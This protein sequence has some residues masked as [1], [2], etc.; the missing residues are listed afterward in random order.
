MILNKS[1]LVEN[2]V[3]EL[4]DNSTGLISPHDIRHNLLDIID[5]VHLLTG[6]HNLN[7]RNFS[8][9]STRTTRV[10]EFTIENLNLAGY[11][12]IDN[13]AFGYEA[14]K[15]NYQGSKNTALG[16]K[17]LFC[18]VY[19]ENNVA[20]GHSSLS[21]N[22]T[23][24]G[25]VA[26]GNFALS[27]NRVGNF[28]IAIGHSAGYYIDR[29]DSY[30]LFIA[31]HPVNEEY[32]CENPN[33]LGLLPLVFADLSGIRFGIGVSGLHDDSA[34]QVGG[35]ATPSSGDTFNLGSSQ[36]SWKNIF[37]SNSIIGQNGSSLS[38]G[39]RVDISGSVL[40]FNHNQQNF[41]S[42]EKAWASG[43]FKDIVVSNTATIAILNAVE[44]CF[45]PCK[46]LYLAASGCNNNLDF[47]EY[48]SDSELVGAGF[49]IFADNG[50]NIRKYNFD[51]LPPS[52]GFV[53]ENNAFAKA[54]WNSNITIAIDSGS[55][56]K[57]N[58]IASHDP[59]GHG[60][61]FNSGITYLSSHKAL[62]S[63]SALA[64]IGNVNF[65]AQSGSIA[66]YFSSLIAIESGVTIGTR[67]LTGSKRY[68][69]D[70]GNFN[71][72]RLNGFD[73]KYIDD[74]LLGVVD[75]KT[76]RLVIGSYDNTSYNQNVVTILQNN[77]DAIFGINN[78]AQISENTLPKTALDIRSTGNAI[79]RATAENQASTVSAIQLMGEQD[80]L[81]N[82]LEACY[83]NTSGFAD[84]NVYKDASK[85]VFF[86][87]Y[88][89]GRIGVFTSS[90]NANEMLTMGDGFNNKPAISMLEASGTFSSTSKYAKIFVK[91]KITPN[92][93]AT[94]N[95]LDGSGNLHD[96]V[97]NKFDNLDGR[98]LYTDSNRNTFGGL[99]SPKTRTVL[100][101]NTK[102]NTSVGHTSLFNVD[103]G[104]YENT[105]LGSYSGSGITSGY[106]NT[107]IGF[108][109]GRNFSTGN[110]NI[111]LGNNA[112]NN[113]SNSIN[114]NIVIGNSGLGSDSSSNYR[115]YLGANKDLVLL[116]GILG[117]NNSDKILT[118]PSGGKFLL[119]NSN[120]SE[121]LLVRNNAIDV[122][123]YGGSD[124]PD[125][126][127]TFNF[128]GNSSANLFKL[129]H[130]ANPLN[131]TP[132]YTV[133]TTPVP[134]AELKGDLRLLGSIRFSDNTSLS[135]AS[136]IETNKNNITSLNSGLNSINNAISTLIVEGYCPLK[137]DAPTNAS[138]PTTGN[139]VIKNSQWIDSSGVI[140]V[141]RDLSLN[142]PQGAY[143]IAVKV[144][145]E[146]RPLSISSQ[147]NCNVCCQ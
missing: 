77:G 87:L 137:I 37:L 2:I 18:N 30:K 75:G 105:V 101:T 90:G 13:S 38:L 24:I 51:F 88:E 135:S 85:A 65:I 53:F 142:I 98:A 17:A 23:G 67:Y 83:V 115:F 4:S 9:P 96:L 6:E 109:S 15:S 86:R 94:L 78:F 122:Y 125:N 95:L 52:S 55:Y 129:N 70:A 68:S 127:L 28:N 146:Y 143:V 113:T 89:N 93:G 39:S 92:Q 123:D 25:N 42:S 56:L 130:V 10:G 74:A 147:E 14:L 1:Q 138:N 128:I 3:T 124:Y 22:S 29:D 145:N 108:N 80:C 140:L 119:Y 133:P 11:S 62:T 116:Q 45:Y 112:F 54:S 120:N 40:P 61:Y 134:Y 20:V 19:G 103:A 8:T 99:L 50:G 139:L 72:E 27:N 32:L 118:M 34:L 57:T 73:I 41:G 43:Y 136:Q 5:S 69:K 100:N 58:R 60:L 110:S 49:N 81:Y 47:C 46:T 132:T 104:G 35:N 111:I 36:Y 21:A 66:N 59:S 26:L 106:R 64:G 31:A 76:S 117:P 33:G 97:V 48:L 44:S 126:E 16:S 131:K 121:G 82:G 102:D 63:S 91:S 71:K 84:I 12:S 7:A 144:N 107:I 79:I 114:N 141:N